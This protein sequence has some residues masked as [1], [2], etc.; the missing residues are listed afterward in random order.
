[1]GRK[2]PSTVTVN[3][4]VLFTP[5][6][7]TINI[8]GN[9]AGL[10]INGIYQGR[11][12]TDPADPELII[13]LNLTNPTV[14][15]GGHRAGE[16]IED[17]NISVGKDIL[18]FDIAHGVFNSLITAGVLID[19]S[20][21]NGSAGGSNIGA[22]GVTDSIFD[23]PQ[24]LA[25][26]EIKNF[27]INGNV[28]SGLGHRI[29]RR[30]ASPPEIIAGEDR[31][32]TWS[33]GGVIDNFQFTGACSSAPCWPRASS[34]MAAT[35][36]QTTDFP[37]RHRSNTPAYLAGTWRAHQLQRIPPASSTPARSP[38]TIRNANYGSCV[39]YF[40]ETITTPPHPGAPAD[41]VASPSY[42]LRVTCPRPREHP[43]R[44]DQ[45]QLRTPPRC[46]LP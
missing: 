24:I 26:S 38:P 30:R 8:Q 23:S 46:R 41:V 31:D 40:N 25:G 33:S 36:L 17:A 22:D 9:V 1:M 11:A 35:A 32:G 12:N 6:A 27:E 21:E 42:D 7:G 19:G 44:S 18:G 39:S 13:G 2:C 29:P 15:G 16:V 37:L 20:Q 43:A 14:L 4:S 5:S 28:Q 10:T 45:P 3:G 34:R